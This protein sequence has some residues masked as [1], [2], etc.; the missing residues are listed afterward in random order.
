MLSIILYDLRRKWVFF[1]WLFIG[2]IVS[3]ITTIF[4]TKKLTEYDR[5]KET[6]K[7]ILNHLILNSSAIHFSN[8]P[9]ESYKS[10]SLALDNVPLIYSK[11]SDVLNK[12][13]DFKKKSSDYWRR[14][15]P[16]EDE[17]IVYD[18]FCNLIY[19]L[20]DDLKIE[21]YSV[22]DIFVS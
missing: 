22:E 15:S 4:V 16:T 12:Y 17:L 10:F 11:N 13:D 19:S 18:S 9:H 6:K 3:S 5:I 2:A 21:R 7:A 14:E 8:S 1:L 20:C